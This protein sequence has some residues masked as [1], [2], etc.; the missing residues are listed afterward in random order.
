MAAKKQPRSQ[1]PAPPIQAGQFFKAGAMVLQ[2][3]KKL[4]DGSWACV[5]YDTGR[6]YAHTYDE[7]ELQKDFVRVVVFELDVSLTLS[8]D[9]QPTAVIGAPAGALATT[10]VQLAVEADKYAN[11]RKASQ[12]PRL[13]GPDQQAD[14]RPARRRRGAGK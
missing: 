9:G 2:A 1:T 12:D 10:K 3:L 6:S 14:G 5:T 7:S 13:A 8:A 4:D 11:A